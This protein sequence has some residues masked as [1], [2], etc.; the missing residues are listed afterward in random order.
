MRTQVAEADPD[1]L[2]PVA[3]L[4]RERQLDVLWEGR[5]QGRVRRIRLIPDQDVSGDY[6]HLDAHGP[7]LTPG[8]GLHPHLPS[9]A[10]H[11]GSPRRGA[12]RRAP[13]VRRRSRR[14]GR[15]RERGAARSRSRG[16]VSRVPLWNRGQ[17]DASSSGNA[18][19][20]RPN[21]SHS[22]PVGACLDGERLGCTDRVG[23]RCRGGQDA[24]SEAPSGT[25][26]R[27]PVLFDRKVELGGIM[28]GFACSSPRAPRWAA[29]SGQ[30]WLE[31]LEP[32]RR[33]CA[34]TGF[35]G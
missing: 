21:T 2:G 23:R 8:V 20:R 9:N 4:R 34:G 25:R 19:R 18:S 12:R 35:C 24:A 26:G 6:D 13:L 28:R 32:P 10:V 31:G 17:V 11:T 3:K 15:G 27:L 30:R 14:P 5:A 29:T 22:V 33:S 1:R 16:T 7:N